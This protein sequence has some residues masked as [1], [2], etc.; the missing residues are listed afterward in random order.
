MSIIA[1]LFPIT[2]CG[3]YLYLNS[4]KAEVPKRQN[5]ATCPPRQSGAAIPTLDCPDTK[6]APQGFM[7][8][9]RGGSSCP[10]IPIGILI[11]DTHEILKP[12]P[13]GTGVGG[14][15]STPKSKH[16]GWRRVRRLP[17]GSGP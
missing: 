1:H 2:T 10:Q 14:S 12:Q 8:A 3:C 5:E 4:E 9:R 7:C 6:A 16:L 13:K 15:L 17:G 11:G